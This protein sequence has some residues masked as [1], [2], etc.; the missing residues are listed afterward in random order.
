MS[1]VHKEYDVIV[2]FLRKAI[3]RELSDEPKSVSSFVSRAL[4]VWNSMSP[5]ERRLYKTSP[6][7][8]SNQKNIK[9]TQE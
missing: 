1:K 2:N 3:D 9:M 6:E 8:S 4:K 5:A 7:S